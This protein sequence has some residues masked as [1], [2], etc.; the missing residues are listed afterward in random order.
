MTGNYF[1]VL[2][3][4]PAAR[5]RPDAGRRPDEGRTPRRR[6]LARLLA[7]AVR[8]R[9]LG[10]RQ[11]GDRQRRVLHDRRR[12]GEDLRR[13]P[14]GTARRPLR[15]DDDETPD[16]AVLGRPRRSEGLLA[17][18][19]RAPEAR[20]L[21]VGGRARARGD[22]SPDPRAA[23]APDDRLERRAQE[24]I[25]QQEDRAAL[26]RARTA[27]AAAGLRQT[28]GLADGDGGPGAPDRLL[29]PGRPARR[30]R[31]RPAARVR[32]PP[33]DR[34]QPRAAAAAVDR[35]MPRLLGRRRRAR[36]AARGLA[37]E[38]P[39]LRVSRRRGPAPGRRPDRSARARVR[40]R[41]V[42][43]R[44]HPLRRRACVPGG[45]PGPRA[46]A[47]RPGP[48]LDDARTRGPSPAQRP[49]HRAGGPDARAARGGR[50]LHAEPAQPLPGR[51]RREARE[52]DRIL[53]RAEAERLHLRAHRDAGAPADRRPQ[54]AARRALGHGGAARHV[55]RQRHGQRRSSWR[56]PTRRPTLPIPA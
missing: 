31:R 18:D 53:R 37:P 12:L 10:P 42:A 17:A 9:S 48:R 55:E 15:A 16:D 30:P 21:A 11:A 29:E 41:P 50:P 8:R 7:A 20:L 14:G 38:R 54:G 26:G 44:G 32:H 5:P 1:G 35:R 52:R 24:G 46:D 27:H 2:G 33:G 39:A 56:A 34:R 25:P 4:P 40:R 51:A 13:H 43:R 36:P 49:R 22:L 23:A 3:V 45:A 6:A 28:A 47:A 19:R